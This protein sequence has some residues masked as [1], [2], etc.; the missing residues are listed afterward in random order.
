[1]TNTPPST[2]PRRVGPAPPRQTGDRPLPPPS[3]AA[4]SQPSPP[5]T[6][7]AAP[8]KATDKSAAPTA[9]AAP[10]LT[11]PD[12]CAFAMSETIKELA[13]VLVDVQTEIRHVP[14]DSV[15]PYYSSD[16][17]SLKVVV[18]TYRTPFAKHGLVVSQWPAG[19]ALVTLLLHRSGEWLRS[20]CTL[21]PTRNDSQGWAS[22]LTYARRYSALAVAGVAPIDDD[23]ESAVDR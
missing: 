10:T 9:T 19:D 5:R 3:P 17:A 12:G 1:M 22:A 11:I 2:G 4:R 16:F 8:Q 15:N 6:E 7:P 14:K 13:A 18:D 23:G 20:A 21:H